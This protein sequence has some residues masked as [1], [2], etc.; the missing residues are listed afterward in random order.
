MHAAVNDIG[1]DGARALAASLEKNTTLV[2]LD[3]RSARL[4]AR[5]GWE[6]GMCGAVPR[7]AAARGR[8]MQG[9]LARAVG[10]RACGVGPLA[11]VARSF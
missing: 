10:R 5:G 11:T 4:C 1:A 7:P 2:K 8:T 9:E 6:G 3:L